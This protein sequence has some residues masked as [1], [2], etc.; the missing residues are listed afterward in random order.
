MLKWTYFKAPGNLE[1]GLSDMNKCLLEIIDVYL[2]VDGP[3]YI[4]AEFTVLTN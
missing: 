4:E 2:L 3:G 1:I